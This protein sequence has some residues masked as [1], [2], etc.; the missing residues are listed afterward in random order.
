MFT[1]PFGRVT[2][3]LRPGRFTVDGRDGKTFAGAE[4]DNIS[5]DDDNGDDT[6]MIF[7]KEFSAEIRNHD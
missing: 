1:G 4:Y 6:D 7:I 3:V 2:A 5:Y